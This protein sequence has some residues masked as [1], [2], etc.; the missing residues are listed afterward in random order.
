M[1]RVSRE[2]LGDDIAQEMLVE[3]G[4]LFARGERQERDR[5][6]EERFRARVSARFPEDAIVGEEMDPS[7]TPF[8]GD[9]W[10]VDPLDGT[11][12]FEAGVPLFCATFAYVVA[13]NPCF[14]WVADPI[15]GSVWKGCLGSGAWRNGVRLPTRPA[16]QGRRIVALS[17]Q[18]RR[19]EADRARALARRAKDRTFGALALELC[20]VADRRLAAG[21][22]DSARA[23]D[24]AA[25]VLIA[26]EAGAIVETLS[27]RPIALTGPGTTLRERQ[28]SLAAWFPEERRVLEP[29]VRGS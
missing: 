6:L 1:Q 17:S 3:L 10:I 7:G 13:G 2:Q 20:W 25:G 27:R 22:W 9:G 23:W 26:R 28:F 24:L 16:R 19:R 8:A 5:E 11:A 4:D 29:I 21:I 18:W 15:E 12:N 14:G